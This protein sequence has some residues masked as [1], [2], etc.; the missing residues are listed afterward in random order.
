M[1]LRILLLAFLFAVLLPLS[2]CV[3]ESENL[4]LAVCGSYAVPGMFCHDLKGGTFT[5][6]V[7]ERDSYG[8]ILFWYETTNII[9]R[10]KEKVYVICQEIDSKYVYFYEDI[11][12]DSLAD[13]TA[14]LDQ[15]KCAND[16][17]QPIQKQRM[18]KRTRE[19]SFDLFLVTE[20]EINYGDAQNA[21]CT[22]LGIREDQI[23][24]FLSLDANPA[25]Q[26]LFWLSADHDGK[27]ELFFV[28][29]HEDCS[30]FWTSAHNWSPME[31]H[32]FKQEN[33]WIY[34]G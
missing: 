32:N 25:G 33:G 2:G 13:G 11:C 26:E 18:S 7:V 17:D 22:S 14:D 16:W 1:K 31:L 28:L 6:N 9:T 4:K 3:D 15:L 8:R 29:V 27:E 10:N 12:Y 30:V 19:I 20:S 34:A 24:A 21:V 23:N 5:C